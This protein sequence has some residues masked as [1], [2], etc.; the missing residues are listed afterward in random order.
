MF[1]P[2][3]VQNDTLTGSTSDD[4]L[5][6][7]AGGDLLYGGD[8]NDSLTGGDG[9][10]VVD[11]GDGNDT[12][13]GD[14]GDDLLFGGAGN[15]SLDGGDGLDVLF[16]GAGLNTL[17]GGAGADTLYGGSIGDR[18]VGGDDSDTLY[19][20]AGDDTLVG[21]LGGDLLDGGV[22]FDTADYSSAS[23]AVLA[24]ISIGFIFSGEAAGD[25]LTS[26]EALVGS[27]F[28]DTLHGTSG[29]QL[30]G[31]DGDDL[32]TDAETMFGGNGNDTLASGYSVYGGSGNDSLEGRFVDG[33][34][35]GDTLSG[36]FGQGPVTLQG[37]EGDDSFVSRFFPFQPTTDDLFIGGNGND[38]LNISVTNAGFSYSVHNTGSL[39]AVG[40][41]GQGVDTVQGIEVLRVARNQAGPG[42]NSVVFDSFA[43]SS[44]QVLAASVSDAQAVEGALTGNTIRFT[45]SLSYAPLLPVTVNYAT[46]DGTAVAGSD[47]TAASGSVTFNAGE[48]SKVVDVVVLNDLVTEST[49]SFALNLTGVTNGVIG[50]GV[51]VGTIVDD[52]SGVSLTGTSGADSLVGGDGDDTLDG[53]AGNDTLRGGGG[54]DSLLGGDGNDL[55]LGGGGGDALYGGAG[56]DSLSG[57][58]T[59]SDGAILDGGAGNDTLTTSAAPDTLFGGDGDDRFVISTVAPGAGSVATGG[60][61]IDVVVV[62]GI[63]SHIV[64]DFLSEIENVRVQAATSG[65]DLALGDASLVAGGTLDVAFD[66]GFDGAAS[67]LRFDGSAEVDGF[68]RLT[69]GLSSDTLTGGGLADTI[70]GG[71]GDDVLAGSGDSDR[72]FGGAGNDVLAGGL[73]NDYLDGGAGADRASFAGNFS[74]YQLFLDDGGPVVVVDL[75]PFDGDDGMDT[76]TGIEG[77]RFADSDIDLASLASSVILSA[78]DDGYLGDGV[79]NTVYGLAGNDS[80]F[81][82]GGNDRLF[83]GSGNDYLDGGAGV[84]TLTGGAGDDY[85]IVDNAGDAV[86]ENAAEGFDRVNV[87]ASGALTIGDNIEEIHGTA[88]GGVNITA[89][90][91]SQDIR[92]TAAAD[93]LSAGDNLDWLFGGA[94]ND[95]LTGGDNGGDALF[96]GADDDQLFGGGG[97][98]AMY[99]DDGADTL[100]GGLGNDTL[101]GGLGADSLVGGDGDDI[102]LVD[103]SADVV[104]ELANEGIDQVNVYTSSAITLA[105]NIELVRGLAVGGVNITAGIGSQTMWGGDAADTLSSGADADWL[106]GGAGADSLAGGDGSDYLHGG[107]GVDTLVG[108]DGD[109]LYVID[110]PADVVTEQASE[111]HDRVDVATSSAVTITNDIG[112]IHGTSAGGVNITAGAGSQD[113]RGTN[114]GDTLDG[115]AD[116]DWLYG[117]AGGDSLT[118]GDGAGDGLYGGLGDDSL[119]GG[120]G[121]DAIYG[122]EDNDLLDGGAGIDTLSGGA[123]DD[124]FVFA[125]GTAGDKDIIVDF[126]V[127]GGDRIDLSTAGVA[128]FAS[129]VH[130]RVGGDTVITLGSGAQIVLQGV[131]DGDLTADEFAFV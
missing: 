84:D 56:N 54:H 76:L 121:N 108:G 109:D 49:E 44:F 112:E 38:T 45:V 27:A 98:D 103:D 99:G 19:G 59:A 53:A 11:G 17:A 115:G 52:D 32:L 122:A 92:G 129:L 88:V 30:S 110:D 61:G 6:G 71:G 46:A 9:N 125:T 131:T 34:D 66:T 33:G 128:D 39:I 22:G 106:Y 86:V 119:Y 28:G 117:G 29:Q 69:G 68:L 58:G 48:T 74:D 55:I 116:T 124:R 18:L 80:L 126:A 43:L 111:G 107:T 100:E 26:V 35:G 70:S 2:G 57:Q 79:A 24:S 91:G 62:T 16:G 72:L 40:V 15:D 105:D 67:A 3:T 114:V 78:G 87:S 127:L 13:T 20:G 60:A 101:G 63:S 81:G 64:L 31:G 123:G 82:N 118:G 97:N 94:G 4:V 51:G 113:M 37:G 41:T 7:L 93:T 50:D 96:G 90:T 85:Y 36:I 21:G 75:N 1:I 25:T 83:G 95:V 102:Y 23:S 65:F 47:F 5:Q 104:V 77:L 130:M 73:G 10:D 120:S 14:A 89:G 42:G 12:V 8:G